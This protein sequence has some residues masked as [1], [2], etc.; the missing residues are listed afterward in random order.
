MCDMVSVNIVLSGSI[1]LR[2]THA[3]AMSSTDCTILLHS[4]ASADPLTLQL[5]A[6]FVQIRDPET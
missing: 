5:Q 1:L 6:T 2:S 4:L 3:R